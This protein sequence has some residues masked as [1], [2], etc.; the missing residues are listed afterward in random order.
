[1]HNYYIGSWETDEDYKHVYDVGLKLGK[2]WSG[3][4]YVFYS[5][6]ANI[7]KG[8]YSDVLAMSEDLNEFGNSFDNSHAR[9]QNYRLISLANLK[10]RKFDKLIEETNKDLKYVT[11]TGHDSIHHVILCVKAQAHIYK[12]ELNKAEIIIYEVEKQIEK[13]KGI[14]VY[15]TQYLLA[16]VKFD[17]EKLKGLP[18]NDKNNNRILR[19]LKK[20][21]NKLVSESKKVVGNLTEAYLLKAK[22][23]LFLKKYKSA[24]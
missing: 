22:M 13:H 15:Y 23:F 4:I 6:L 8:D 17:L 10:F 11:A 9:A 3:T 1:M 2:F 18:K 19:E 12:D 5:G 24:L 21:S 16:K 7:E 14:P 20:N